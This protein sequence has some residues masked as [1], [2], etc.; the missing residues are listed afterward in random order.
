MPRRPGRS[1]LGLHNLATVTE[2]SE[3][4]PVKSQATVLT[5]PPPP[6]EGPTPEEL[7]EADK[8]LARMEEDLARTKVNKTIIDDDSSSEESS[9]D[10]EEETG[11]WSTARRSSRRS[12]VQHLTPKERAALRR[13]S[14]ILRDGG[15]S[16]R[17][18]ERRDSLVARQEAKK[19]DEERRRKS[20][21]RR[22]MESIAKII[23]LSLVWHWLERVEVDSSD[24]SDDDETIA[25]QDLRD[26]EAV[27]IV[28]TLAAGG[29]LTQALA[30]ELQLDIKDASL[31]TVVL[32]TLRDLTDLRV[33][34]ASVATY[35]AQGFYN[36]HV[37]LGDQGIVV[38]RRSW[39]DFGR[40][41]RGLEDRGMN[42]SVLPKLPRPRA[43]SSAKKVFR[44]VLSVKGRKGDRI[45]EKAKVPVLSVWLTKVIAL[46]STQNATLGTNTKL[47][48]GYCRSAPEEHLEDFLFKFATVLTTTKDRA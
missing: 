21:R 12:S 7:A 20:D 24:S 4:S 38:A 47:M 39:R 22:R 26:T 6:P 17:A 45:W 48:A 2:E 29:G 23:D 42:K 35:D 10:D 44:N 25:E 5:P 18:Q 3:V 19:I 14:T 16:R 8:E 33:L 32:K 11:R 1:A 31:K 37:H 34:R 40:L 30:K 36:V 13:L 46:V 27:A 9:S 15:A 41:R 43:V 28:E